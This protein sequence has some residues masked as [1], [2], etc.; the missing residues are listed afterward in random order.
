MLRQYVTFKL[1][2]EEYGVDIKDVQEITDFEGCTEIPDMPKF[3]KGIINIR[4]TI[5]PVIDLKERL[6]IIKANEKNDKKIIII[7]VEGKQIGFIIDS[8]SRVLTLNDEQIDPTPEIISEVV[9]NYII[10]VG[11][12]GEELMLILDLKKML[13]IKELEEVL[14]IE[15]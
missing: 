4:G 7:N 1:N 3:I 5:T 10:G 14:K 15:E 12:L 8:A 9:E 6:K 11:K 13:T 2:G